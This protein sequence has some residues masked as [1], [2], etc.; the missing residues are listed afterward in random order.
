[1]SFRQKKVSTTQ[2]EEEILDKILSKWNN[3]REVDRYEVQNMISVSEGFR[4]E[5]L[6]RAVKNRDGD[7]IVEIL[8]VCTMY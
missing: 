1:M 4:E 3:I 8:E 2:G 5:L 6:H 7:L